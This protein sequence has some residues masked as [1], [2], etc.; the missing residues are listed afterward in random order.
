MKE[1]ALLILFLS[2]LNSFTQNV[3]ISN[4]QNNDTIYESAACEQRATFPGGYAKM[5]KYIDEHIKFPNMYCSIEGKVYVRFVV[6]KTGE[7]E[8]TKVIRAVDPLLDEEAIR[9][10][11]SLPKWE[12]AKIKGELVNSWFIV[13]VKFKLF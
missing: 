12:P 5:F 2:T 6:T 13:P 11:N 7:I 1:I 4:V 10:V 3:D 9:V 8:Q